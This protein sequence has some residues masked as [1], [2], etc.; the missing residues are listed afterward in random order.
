MQILNS[1]LTKAQN[2][3]QEGSQL[4]LLQTKTEKPWLSVR[5]NLVIMNSPVVD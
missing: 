2:S 4:Q 1:L 5:E 3:K